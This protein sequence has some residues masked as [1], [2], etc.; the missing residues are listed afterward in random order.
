MGGPW[1]KEKRGRRERK[2]EQRLMLDISH[3]S[4]YFLSQG[5]SLKLRSTNLAIL[6]QGSSCFCFLGT[7]IG[8]GMFISPGCLPWY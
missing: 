2:R 5:L 8:T 6:S 3:S 4:H 7:G 1:E